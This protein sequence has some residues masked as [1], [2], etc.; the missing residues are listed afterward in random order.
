MA[1]TFRV[2]PTVLIVFVV[3]VAA[4]PLVRSQAGPIQHKVATKVKPGDVGWHSSFA[5]ACTASEQS[6]KPVLLFQLLGNLDQEFC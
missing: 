6:G 5:A 1:V 4:I 2:L 3:A